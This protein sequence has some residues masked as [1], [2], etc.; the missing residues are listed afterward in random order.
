MSNDQ[1]IDFKIQ[2]LD[3][4]WKLEIGHWKFYF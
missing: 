3:I 1:I 4:Y 2:A